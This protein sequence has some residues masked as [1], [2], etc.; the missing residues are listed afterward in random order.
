MRSTPSLPSLP[1]PLWP[2][3]VATD[4]VALCGWAAKTDD[5]FV[6]FGAKPDKG[7]LDLKSR[8]IRKW[9]G[10]AREAVDGGPGRDQL[11]LDSREASKR[12]L[13]WNPGQG[14]STPDSGDSSRQD[15]VQRGR[16][17]EM[18]AFQLLC[19]IFAINP[20]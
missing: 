8:R 7:F 4:S 6:C 16:R 18:T 9:E 15:G 5:S 19:G 14:Q 17:V 3:V 2:G 10:D 20:R 11:A 1:D 12:E 13:A